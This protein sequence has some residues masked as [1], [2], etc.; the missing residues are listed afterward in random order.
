MFARKV[1]R[2][3][4]RSSLGRLTGCRSST[5]R[6]AFIHARMP[7]EREFYATIVNERYASRPQARFFFMKS[8]TTSRAMMRYVSPYFD[9][10]GINSRFTQIQT[11]TQ[12]TFFEVLIRS[13]DD[14]KY[15][16]R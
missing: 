5:T 6:T 14:N 8:S 7:S 4:N 9:S 11:A 3:R 13:T 10:L 15:E 16:A 12:L 1:G 2:L